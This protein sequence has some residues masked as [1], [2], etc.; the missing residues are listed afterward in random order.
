MNARE[1]D[2]LNILAGKEEAQTATDIAEQ[3][4][5]LTQS[6]VIAVLRKLLKDNQ[7]EVVGVAHSGKVLSRT[8]AITAAGRNAVLEHFLAELESVKNVI[9]LDDIITAWKGSKG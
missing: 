9:T 2:V 6:T 3:M 5:G 1:L 8:Y 7:V 4:K